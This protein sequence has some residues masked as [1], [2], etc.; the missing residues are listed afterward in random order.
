MLDGKAVCVQFLTFVLGISNDMVANARKMEAVERKVPR[1]DMKATILIC[2]AIEEAAQVAERQP[3]SNE[4][5]LLHPS[6][7]ALYKSMTDEFKSS[8]SLSFFR[9]VWRKHRKHVKLRKQMR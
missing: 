9:A 1:R 3:D 8:L 7:K 5:H 2:D 6:R 4:I